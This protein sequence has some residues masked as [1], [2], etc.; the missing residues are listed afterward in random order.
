[1][2]TPTTTTTRNVDPSARSRRPA[3]GILI[4]LAVGL[5]LLG[6]AVGLNADQIKEVAARRPNLWGFVLAFG[7]YYGGVLLAYA[8][9]FL[10]VRALGLPC[11]V[12]DALRLGMIG[13]LFNMVIP[14]A[15]GGD[16]VKAAYF[17]RSQD[18]KGQAIASIVIDRI[19][20]LIGLFALASA[21]GAYYWN[22]LGDRPRGLVVAAW[23]ALGVTF[24]LL[25]LAFAINP[26]APLAR[27]LS[28]RRSGAKFV[29][30]L[31]ETGRAYRGRPW[32]VALATGMAATTHLG[33]VLAFAAVT[34]SLYP[35]S[36]APALAIH[37]MVVPL[38]LLSTAIPVPFSG[39]GA[40]ENVSALL[41]RALGFLGGAPSMLG[42]RLLQFLGAGIGALA[43]A[44]DRRGSPSLRDASASAAEFDDPPASPVA[45]GS[46]IAS[47]TSPIT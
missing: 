12:M 6:L 33:N 34:G 29:T 21:T 11:R 36:E 4:R 32:V 8:R 37:L 42:F 31:A 40:A 17:A 27:R 41:F 47:T 25:L 35:L 1:M 16:V 14:G 10:L 39:L 5:G 38:V 23:I 7:L 9:W 28:R 44:S 18:R 15:V 30:E 26:R 43:Y 19:V 24:G 46:P 22:G 2:T 45:A 3:W 20:G 13:T